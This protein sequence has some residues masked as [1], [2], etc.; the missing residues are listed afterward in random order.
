MTSFKPR[1]YAQGELDILCGMYA[2]VNATRQAVG[3]VR[4]FRGKECLWL[5][6]KLVAHLDRTKRLTRAL[7]DGL[8]RRQVGKLLDASEK[9]LA[10]RFGVSLS[11]KRPFH[12]KSS[13]RLS[14]IINAV[15]GHQRLPATAV[16]IGFS[17]HW[18]V[19]Q[20]VSKTGF[21][22]LDSAGYDRLAFNDV[23]VGVPKDPDK[24]H[25]IFPPT[26]IYLLQCKDRAKS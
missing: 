13:I 5:F 12:G 4:P 17:G 6:G 18:S 9:A 24:T 20:S 7:T 22:L 15:K 26:R 11:H 8:N 3:P 1:A 10:K 25:W 14:K 16:L 19:V 23:V 2:V 21:R